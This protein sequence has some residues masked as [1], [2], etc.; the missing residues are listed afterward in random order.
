LCPLK[1]RLK[2]SKMSLF[3]LFSGKLRNIKRE[4]GD[5]PPR[6]QDLGEMNRRGA[7]L[8]GSRNRR[9]ARRD[10]LF[11]AIRESMTRSGVLSASY[12]F[13]VLSLD[14]IGNEFL[15]MM[16]LSSEFEGSL[17]Q[18]PAMEAAIIRH[19]KA[20]LDIVL[21]AVYWRSDMISIKST[22]NTPSTINTTIPIPLSASAFETI[23]VL[24]PV[25]APIGEL[26]K[27]H[28]TL[29]PTTDPA[30][31]VVSPIL[32]KAPS[33]NIDLEAAAF[34]QALRAASAKTSEIT[35]EMDMHKLSRPR[36]YTLLTGFEDTELSENNNDSGLSKTQYGNLK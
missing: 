11:S 10:Q 18:L 19:A 16:D 21:P 31:R 35:K 12:K 32:S 20:R 25:D 5:A 29:R 1:K 7:L 24:A 33:T 2:I 34:Q 4:S 3:N 6:Q 15:V 27:K 13:K 8:E 36:S 26:L 23:A 9:H 17:E 28:S 14:Q 30:E 22:V